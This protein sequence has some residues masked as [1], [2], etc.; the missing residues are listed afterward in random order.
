V[1]TKANMMLLFNY[2][3]KDESNASDGLWQI[4]CPYFASHKLKTTNSSSF[5]AV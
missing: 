4:K 2:N 1:L 5:V 3:K